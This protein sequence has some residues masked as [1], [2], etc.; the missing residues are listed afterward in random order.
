MSDGINA[1][2]NN[3]VK[4][5]PDSSTNQG[6]DD[7]SMIVIKKATKGASEEVI[8]ISDLEV[9]N[10]AARLDKNN[11]EEEQIQLSSTSSNQILSWLKN[12]CDSLESIVMNDEAHGEEIEGGDFFIFP[13]NK[14]I[15]RLSVQRIVELTLTGRDIR[16]IGLR[17]RLS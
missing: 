9:N 8:E 14:Q 17:M 5:F 12:A 3:E 6:N 10:D 7:D 11:Y 1:E 4:K 2:A 13:W 15:F 16:S